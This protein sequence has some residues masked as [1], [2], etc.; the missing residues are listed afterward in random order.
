MMH[1]RH[2]GRW[3]AIAR[4]KYDT[5]I[6]RWIDKARW[7]N[8][9]S[10]SEVGLGSRLIET[11]SASPPRFFEMYVH[12]NPVLFCRLPVRRRL[13]LNS[14]F[15]SFSLRLVSSFRL[16]FPPLEEKKT[17]EEKQT[18]VLQSFSFSFR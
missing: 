10:H 7:L 9:T 11:T 1:S 12:L 6:V 8:R 13:S 15:L 14:R 5:Q 3:I 18:D 4:Q 16:T 17:R 2:I